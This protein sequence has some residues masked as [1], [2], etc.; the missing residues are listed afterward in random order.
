M[1]TETEL[2]RRMRL[3]AQERDDLPADW[4]QQAQKFD[5]AAAG[6]HSEPQTVSAKQF[7]G[8]FARTRRMW[9]DVTGEPL[10]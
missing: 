6:F 3:L 8:H 10:V 1:T 9:C 5:E 2:S 4:L 7:L